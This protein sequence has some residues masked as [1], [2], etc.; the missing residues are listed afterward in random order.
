MA[1]I[2]LKDSLTRQKGI[3][4]ALYCTLSEL[5]REHVCIFGQEEDQWCCALFARSLS[6]VLFFCDPMTSSPPGSSLH[7]TS[8]ARI[9][10]WVPMSSSRG[11]SQPRDRTHVSCIGKWVLL[12]LSHRES[13]SVDNRYYLILL[14]FTPDTKNISPALQ[15]FLLQSDPAH[16]PC[17]SGRTV[18]LRPSTVLCWPGWPRDLW[19][20]SKPRM[21]PYFL[22]Y[23]DLSKGVGRAGSTKAPPWNLKHKS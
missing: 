17:S 20:G 7:G 11:S 16:S 5:R 21:D 19:R 8:Q 3:F 14:Y 6:C 10:E 2:F 23:N 12:S 13:P 1:Y 18:H 15:N 4:Q 9:L 22:L